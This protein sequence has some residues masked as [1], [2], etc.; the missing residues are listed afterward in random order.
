MKIAI[1]GLGQFGYA[2]LKHLDSALAQDYEI[3]GYDSAIKVTE[4]LASSREHPFLF[5]G[6]KIS[7]KITILYTP[8]TLLKNADVVIVAVPSHL[9]RA[10]LPNF[11]KYAKDRLIVMNTA[12]ALD[13][14][15]GKRLS[16]LFNESIK[17]IN[18]RYASFAGGTI[19][20]DLF[21]NELLG[22]VIASSEKETAK[23][24][25]NILQSDKLRLQTSD[26]LAGVEYASA[27]KNTI[28]ILTGIIHGK[29]FSYGS[30]TFIIS[31]AAAEIEHLILQELGGK[32]ETFS[33]G[34]TCW[35]NDMF[36]SATGN[37]RNREFGI[38]IG[39]GMKPQ[40]A[41]ELMESEMKTVEGIKTLEA[42][43]KITNISKYPLLNYLYSVIILYE[44]MD[45]LDIL[46]EI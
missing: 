29:G 41:L 30:E 21:N 12:K 45:I 1:Y 42:I 20:R 14:E 27:F 43:N 24:L 28:S 3:C 13:F 23:T 46:K 26:D 7:K 15:T 39:K 31:K 2:L 9:T 40:Q 6:H 25:K 8:E 36:M 10:I 22:A 5:K 37:T 17:N 35:G 18:L 38:L 32:N 16:V 19:A 44:N 11:T 4:S 34:S 33:V